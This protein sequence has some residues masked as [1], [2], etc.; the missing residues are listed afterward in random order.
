MNSPGFPVGNALK[1]KNYLASLKKKIADQPN[2]PR[3]QG[4]KMQAHHV[5]SAE[6]MKNSGLSERIRDLGYDINHT[7]NLV[8]IPCTLQG[9]CY[10]GVQP[11][12]GNHTA[13]ADPDA[14]DDDTEP[15]D[16][17]EMVTR[18]LTGLDLPLSKDCPGDDDSKHV[19]VI[20]GL[21]DLSAEIVEF[22]QDAPGKAPLTNIAR[23]F[24]PESK[25]GCGGV[26]S[27]T[28]H[29]RNV[30]C[31]VG[32]DHFGRQGPRQSPENIEFKKGIAYTLRVGK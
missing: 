21:N 17:H 19:K 7:K 2:H 11:H 26:D 18:K 4:V 8:F 30:H 29:P 20:K 22:I 9:A 1:S 24:A 32:R 12:R 16:Y 10:L 28:Q 6:G 15:D 3:H 13:L 23:F 5:I 31:A 14:Y 25:I 27:V